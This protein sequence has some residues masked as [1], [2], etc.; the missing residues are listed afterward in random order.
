MAF[1]SGFRLADKHLEETMIKYD[2]TITHPWWTGGAIDYVQKRFNHKSRVFEY[3]AGMSSRWLAVRCGYLVTVENNPEWYSRV[4]KSLGV[5][6]GAHVRFLEEENYIQAI[7]KETDK[8]DL[9]IIDGGYREQTMKASMGMV[10]LGGMMLVDD[11]QASIY[12]PMQLNLLNWARHSFLTD[13][14]DKQ[15]K[16]KVTCVYVNMPE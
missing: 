9:V 6:K 8:F 11:A 4:K 1:Q 15:H 10:K 16:G 14:D 2:P 5:C 3:G 13:G 12:W 7:T